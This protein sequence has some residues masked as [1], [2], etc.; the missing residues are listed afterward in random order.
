M[1]TISVTI[2][3]VSYPI[4]IQS[5]FQ[6]GSTY[7]M[8]DI[9]TF[10]I[11][12]TPGTASF[13]RGQPVVFSDSVAGTTYTGYVASDR[14]EKLSPD[15]ASTVLLHTITCMDPQY[16][17]D[18]R[19]N[20]DNYAGWQAGDIVA[21]MAGSILAGEGVGLAAAMRY[22]NHTSDFNQGNNNGT[23]GSVSVPTNT[24]N[25]TL[26]P[27]GVDFTYTESTTADF[28]TGTLTNCTAVNNA[29]VPTTV[30]AMK[31]VS[32]LNSG[33]VG[34]TICSMK[35]WAGSVSISSTTFLN[36]DIFIDPSSPQAKASLN[37]FFSDGSNTT[38]T[39]TILGGSPDAQFFL[40]APT[41]DLTGLATIGWYAH[42]F[43]IGAQ[44]SGKTAVAIS[45]DIAGTTPGTYTAYIK[46]ANFSGPG[47]TTIFSS[48]LSVN[49]PQ[50]LQNYGYTAT[51][52]TVVDVYNLYNY[53][54]DDLYQ[55][56]SSHRL[57]N[58]LSIGSVK[59]LKSSHISW[60]VVQPAHTMLA[61]W[62][63][64]DDGNAIRCTNN[65]PLP[66]LPPGIDLTGKHITLDYEFFA[67]QG[68]NPE[69]APILE[70]IT[71]TLNTSY[72]CVKT[73]VTYAAN[74]QA[75]WNA[76]TLT[77]L[78]ANSSNEI[79]LNG[80]IKNW[81]NG[82]TAG[83]SFYP[84]GGTGAQEQSANN[85]AFT[86]WHITAGSN[87][88]AKSRV[89]SAGQWQNFTAEVDV[90]LDPGDP[91]QHGFV[92]RTTNWQ[93]NSG[94]AAYYV[95]ATDGFVLMGKGANS[96]SSSP[97]AQS[98]LGS[99]GS[100]PSTTAS[101]HRLKAVVSGNSHNIYMDDVHILAVTDA[102]YTAAGYIGLYTT[103]GG[104]SASTQ[105]TTYFDN[106]GVV[107]SLS[108]TWLSPSQSLTSAGT[109]GNSIIS[110]RDKSAAYNGGSN[111][112]ILVEVTYNGGSTWATCTNGSALPGL[113]VGQSLAGVSAQ[114]RITLSS[115]TAGS[116]AALDNF[117]VRV[118]GAYNSS[119]NR[120]TLPLGF[121][122]FTRANQSGLGTASNGLTWTKTG[123]GTDA[124]SGNTAQI[125]NT[126]GDVFETQGSTTNTDMDVT[127][128]LQL[129]AG[130][131][132]AGMVLRY[133]NA[134]NYYL[135]AAS[136]T[137][138][139]IIKN[140]GGGKVTLATTPVTL[141]TGT[142]Y[143]L[144]FRVVG[145]GPVSL[146]GKV[147]QQGTLE[148]GIVN[149]VLSP[150]TPMWTVTASD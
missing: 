8:R 10:T 91:V 97:G 138:L 105:Y 35:I 64:L 98:I 129:S 84:S 72:S 4:H 147:W 87:V 128:P 106:F 127:I 109:Y 11:I 81:D 57:T 52:V 71:L 88:E 47:A 100:L 80:Y 73:D 79:T 139:A 146:Q 150:I 115:S 125:S 92:Y 44:Y 141:S 33:N 32:T 30:K 26:S 89:D 85:R 134:N 113:T 60:D 3:G 43:N 59:L 74:V 135:L 145:Q 16:D 123:T 65:A 42:G 120:T 137:G 22:E 110:W 78:V 75:D 104:S 39:A 101:W 96:S 114:F 99:S 50:Q 53:P 20:P 37:I 58:T 70:N 118:L 21:N 148:P 130:T 107:A 94:S 40:P 9:L 34:N 116:L 117:T 2:S 140:T 144:R 131:M 103:D 61:I 86:I 48:T 51:T 13:Q 143:Y 63:S 90:K 66:D 149:G 122:T 69:V 67:L 55:L 6:D 56:A 126:T 112:T 1:S 132:Q 46:N 121:D 54:T 77:N 28:S 15:P 49:P 142:G 119:G 41:S 25:L 23:T 18:K 36:Y 24:G 95:W 124:I 31:M 133:T 108:G 27:S 7:E 102:T 45:F 12:D 136:T 68:A 17:V 83:Q 82:S 5:G 29:L 93:N 76:G 62:Y 19:S 14:P 111:T 38:A